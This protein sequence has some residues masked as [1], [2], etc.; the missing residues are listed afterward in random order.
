MPPFVNKSTAG[1]PGAENWSFGN[2]EEWFSVVAEGIYASESGA[3]S[4]RTTHNPFLWF[5]NANKYAG[6]PKNFFHPDAMTDSEFFAH[7]YLLA[8][9]RIMIQEPTIYNIMKCSSA[10]FNPV[11]DFD[12]QVLGTRK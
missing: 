7:R 10:W 5:F 8:I 4:V 1:D 3:T 11:K 9:D 12:Q 6:S 2:W